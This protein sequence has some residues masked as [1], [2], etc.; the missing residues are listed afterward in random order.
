MSILLGLRHI[1]R[2]LVSRRSVDAETLEELADHVERQTRKHVAAGMTPIDAER[3]A[4]IELGGMQRWRD[5]NAETRAGSLGA[6]IAADCRFT[7]RTLW[8]RPG[9]TIVA[10]LSL[11]LGLGAATAIF[12]VIDG[13]LLRPLPFPDAD[14]LMAVSLRMPN[15]SSRTIVDMVWSYPKYVMFRDQQHAFDAVALHS[16]ESLTTDG[17]DGVERVSGEGVT[18]PYF[19]LLGARPARGRIFTTTEDSIGAG[20]TAVIVSDAFWRAR[21]G[22]D[23]S[24]VGRLIDV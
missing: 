8:K 9:F 20:G 23:Q 19:S 22:A 14:R 17:A 11:A 18:S 1:L 15:R 2:S 13:T 12:A 24:A 5:E 6:S 4:R 21:L 7:L 16:V 10:V 3:L